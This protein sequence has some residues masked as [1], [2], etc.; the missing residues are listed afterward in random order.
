MNHTRYDKQAQSEQWESDRE[1]EFNKAMKALC[2]ISFIAICALT[3][4]STAD[5]SAGINWA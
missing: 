3:I 4:I 5:F 1:R 2:A